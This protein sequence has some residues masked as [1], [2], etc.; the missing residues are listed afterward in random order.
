MN[1]LKL[2]LLLTLTLSFTACSSGKLD[3]PEKVGKH[4]FNLLTKID[5]T[6]EAEYLA[7]FMTSEE[8]NTLGNNE[9]LTTDKWS[10][11]FLT[12]ITK[13]ALAIELEDRYNE[14]I[15]DAKEIGMVWENIEYDKYDFI[16]ES[17]L[18]ST[19]TQGDLLFIYEGKRY[20]V[21]IS[22]IWDGEEYRL[23]RV[24]FLSAK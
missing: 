10:K 5:S 13:E 23:A 4:V 20:S 8:M 22:T 2:L 18:A 11:D 1:K 19:G 17:E 14:L 24:A 21:A 7:N 16:T 15:E 9:T 6:P 3:K 12:S